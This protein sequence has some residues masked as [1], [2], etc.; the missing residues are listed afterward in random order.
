LRLPAASSLRASR[1][2]RVLPSYTYPTAAATRSSHGLSFPS[3]LEEP[4]V[5]FS[6]VRPPATF[7]LQGLVTLLTACALESRAG[8]VSHRQRSWDSPFGGFPF[9]KASTT[10]Q[11]GRTRIPLTRRLFRRRSVEP[12]RRVSV[13]GSIPPGSALRPDRFLSRRPPVPPMGFTPLRS[14]MKALTRAS[15]RLLS[16]TLQILVITHRTR[17][18]LRVSIGL[19]SAPPDRCR[20]TCRT[21]QPFWGSCTCPFLTIRASLCLGYGVHLA[22]RRT[23]LPT[24]RRSLGTSKT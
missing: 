24:F 1:P 6:R 12:A 23:L 11:P 14:A 18:C 22:P 15:P 7:R 21:K 3:A 4:E 8:F 13:P 2:S 20:S 19:H 17:W 16:R 10:F 5:H 9:Q